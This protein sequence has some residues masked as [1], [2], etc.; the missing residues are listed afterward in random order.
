MVERSVLETSPCDRV[1]APA[2]ESDRDRVLTDEEVRWLWKATDR[3][4]YPFGPFVRLLLLT[5]QRRDEVAKSRWR[6]F[7]QP[8]LWHIPAERTKNGIATDVPLS[9]AAQDVVAS[10]P[11]IGRAG[12]L[13]TSNGE[14]AISGYSDAKERLDKYMVAVAREEAQERGQD[15]DQV[16]LRPWRLHDLRRTLASGMARLEHPPHVVEAVLNHRAGTISGVAAV[17]N[18]YSYGREKSR[19]LEAWGQY[20]MDLVE[21][22]ASNVVTLRRDV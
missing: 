2:T 21:G 17:Y 5:G 12:Y 7:P 16:E 8:D 4:R 3:L 19:A 11:R 22:N 9:A 15:P 6:E 18:R 1:K 20:V 14:T 10:L 13:F